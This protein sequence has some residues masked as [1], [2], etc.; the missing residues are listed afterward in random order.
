M[1]FLIDSWIKNYDLLTIQKSWRNV[2]VSTFYN[3]FNID[4]HLLYEDIENVKIW[5]YVNTRLHVN[6]WFVDFV[7]DDV[8]IIRIKVVNDKWINVHNVYNV[9]LNFYKT[10]NILATIEIVKNRLNNDEEHILLKDFNLHHSLWSKAIKFIQH[11][12]TN[13]L[14][15]V[16]QQT[17][18]RFILFSNTIIWKTRHFQNTID[19]MFM[20][21][22]LQKK[23]IHCMTRSKM[24]QSLNHISIFTKLML[25]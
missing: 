11:D 1:S 19:L 13:Q 25:S 8:C 15:N 22:E 17:Q 20:T 21:K 3:S 12:A 24:N 14:L 18:L 7:I 6:H 23:L 2:C 16:V 10:R 9:L 4:F 5:F